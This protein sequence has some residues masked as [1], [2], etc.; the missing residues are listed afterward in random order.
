MGRTAIAACSRPPNPMATAPIASGLTSG[1]NVAA[2][3]VVPQR[4]EAA[5]TN[6]APQVV[7]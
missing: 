7:P 6:S 1:A 4:T 2:V 3:P 5:S